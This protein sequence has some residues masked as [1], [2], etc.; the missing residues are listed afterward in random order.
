MLSGRHRVVWFSSLRYF[1]D[2]GLSTRDKGCRST[3][4]NDTIASVMFFCFPRSVECHFFVSSDLEGHRAE[5]DV[6]SSEGV[7][8]AE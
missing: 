2:A 4:T 1:L 7:L 6:W 3:A 8:F 5:R